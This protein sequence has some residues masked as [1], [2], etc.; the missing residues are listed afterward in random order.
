M[1]GLNSLFSSKFPFLELSGRHG[2]S[3]MSNA[4]PQWSHRT[5][6][7]VIFK[8]RRERIS[9]YLGLGE[10]LWKEGCLLTRHPAKAPQQGPLMVL[11][12]QYPLWALAHVVYR[13]PGSALAVSSGSWDQGHRH[14]QAAAFLPVAEQ[15]LWLQ[16][17]WEKQLPVHVSLPEFSGPTTTKTPTIYKAR[18]YERHFT[19]ISFNPPDNPT[20]KVFPSSFQK[21]PEAQKSEVTCPRSPSQEVTEVAFQGSTFWL[22]SLL[23]LQGRFEKTVASTHV[24]QRQTDTE[25]EKKER[26]PHRTLYSELVSYTHTTPLSYTTST[27]HHLPVHILRVIL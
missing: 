22:W 17:K 1:T 19:R 18:N 8:D 7:L 2:S 15:T 4:R 20:G 25:L 14:R 13:S 24:D 5:L 16:P 10:P 3:C 9:S 27:C 12:P 11:H 6:F 23:I 21:L 26:C